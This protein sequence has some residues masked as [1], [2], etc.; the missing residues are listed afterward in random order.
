[1]MVKQSNSKRI[2]KNTMFMYV[3]M[4]IVLIIALYSSR[5][6]LRNLGIED[7]GTYSLV[8]SIVAMVSMFKPTFASAIQRFMNYEM[9]KKRYDRIQL[10]FSMSIIINIIISLIFVVVVEAMGI[11]FFEYKIN[12]DPSR[13]FAAKVVFQLSVISAVLSI[14]T[15]P[16]DALVIAREQFNFY[17]IVSV[18]DSVLRLGCAL[19]IPYLS[20]DGLI[21]YG[22]LI[23]AAAIINRLINGLY[24]GRHYPESH[25]K[26]GWD[27]AL[28]KDLMSFSGWQIM[29]F[30]AWTISQNGMNL[31][32]NVFGGPVVNAARGVTTHVHSAVTQFL[33]NIITVVTPYSIKAY[34]EGNNEGVSR[35]F[36]FST[37]ILFVCGYCIAIPIILLAP[38]IL[39]IWLEE[40]PDYTI[41]FVQLIMVWFVVRSFHQPIDTLFKAAGKIRDYQVTES[42]LCIMPLFASA[43]ML[44]FGLSFYMAL[45]TIIIFDV[46]NLAAILAL[47]CKET[48]FAMA[49]YLREVLL[50]TIA[51]MILGVV[52]YLVIFQ[53]WHMPVLV[54]IA[55]IAIVECLTL[56]YSYLIVLNK[57]EKQ[58]VLSFL[59]K[60]KKV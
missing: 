18:L 7:Y 21:I 39:D 35:M 51:P 58:V 28:F 2:A 48:G 1:M 23:L 22:I 19:V 13:L 10:I 46:I 36:Y 57:E 27:K 24:C 16:Y 26:K 15:T 54:S 12:I 55:I 34:A 45:S 33:N 20:G 60:N 4:A 37:K 43:I 59:K 14:M 38:Q 53:W 25:F 49:R 3:R 32:F 42:V 56:A 9:G 11:W 41:G 52:S 50:P 44:Q 17:A 5:I 29:G 8:G 47:L 6:L 31:V 40:V 30:S